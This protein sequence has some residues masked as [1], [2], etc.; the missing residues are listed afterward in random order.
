MSTQEALEAGVRE[1]LRFCG[2]EVAL[3][4]NRALV[5]RI[6]REAAERLRRDRVSA[7]LA[8]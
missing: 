3:G 8:R 7:E 6:A 5:D 1:A 2:Y 4:R